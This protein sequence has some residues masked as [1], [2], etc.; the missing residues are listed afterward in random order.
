M[1]RLQKST[2]ILGISVISGFTTLSIGNKVSHAETKYYTNPTY[3]R[4]HCWYSKD[5]KHYY[6]Y[7]FS[8]HAMSFSTRTSNSKWISYKTAAKHYSIGRGNAI[9]GWDVFGY[10][11]SDAAAYYHYG[12][13]TIEGHKVHTLDIFENTIGSTNYYVD[14]FVPNPKIVGQYRYKLNNVVWK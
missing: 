13:H 10:R 4:N 1:N 8:K 6:R 11:D 9:K 5:S 12:T 2:I 14:I 3:L 7:Y